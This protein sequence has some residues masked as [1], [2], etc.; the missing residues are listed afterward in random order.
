MAQKKRPAVRRSGAKKRRRRT[1]RA[2]PWLKAAVAFLAL[3]FA[4]GAGYYFGYVQG[5]EEHLFALNAERQHS[6][7]LECALKEAREKTASHEY[8][9]VPPR[10]PKRTPAKPA[11]SRVANDRPMLAIIIDDVSFAHD[12]RNIERLGIP[13]TMSFLPPS[14]RHPDSAKL[15]AKVPFYMVHLPLEAMA[16]SG[17][18]P[19]TLH[20]GDS[21]EA[22]EARIRTLKEQFPRVRFV[23]NHTGSRF[24]SDPD[25]MRKL[26]YALDR[27]G[28]TFVDSRTTGKTAVPALMRSLHRPYLARDVFLDHDPDTEAVERQIRRAVQRAKKYGYAVAIGHPH[29]K[30][31]AA[32]AAS[33][34]VLSQVELVRFD[35]LAAQMEK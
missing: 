18:E 35:T 33:R 27:E 28:I 13:L 14:P 10:P 11:A 16:F 20:V 8:E 21:A 26:V 4:A 19:Q 17:E 29:K 23:N 30:T 9:K 25:A 34:D 12:V 15:A 6:Y 5:K 24:T 3:F 22:I 1:K 31:L 32:L 7:E 2:F